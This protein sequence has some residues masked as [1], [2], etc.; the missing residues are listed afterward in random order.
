MSLESIEKNTGKLSANNP[1]T[2][3]LHFLGLFAEGRDI[4][5]VYITDK[6]VPLAEK[7][8]AVVNRVE[9][10]VGNHWIQSN[11]FLSKLR[12]LNGYVRHKLLTGPFQIYG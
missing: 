9:A 7:E 12:N 3:K 5:A 11:A 8:I 4:N 6:R 1:G 10:W 2:V